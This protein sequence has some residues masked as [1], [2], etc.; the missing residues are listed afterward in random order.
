MSLFETTFV[1]F[2]LLL[3]NAFFSTAEFS[4][5]SSRK[6]KLQQLVS[7]GNQNA[8]KVID[9]SSNPSS[10]ITVIQLSLNIIA[11]L[12]GILGEQSFSSYISG[13]LTEWGVSKNIAEILSTVATVL[14]I[15]SV[16][17]VFAE[18]IPKR[19]AFSNPERVA[20][21]VIT[22]LLF[23]LLLF[24]PLVF[25][26][27]SVAEV[28]LKFFKISTQRDDAVTFEDMSAMINQGAKSGILEEKSII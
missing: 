8:Q 2:L 13:V 4:I 23:F 16:F 22:P 15:T 27:S 5:A 3:L 7:E 26:L 12:S 17:I 20:T 28:I 6:L 25:V 14:M 11:I 24:K 1:L 18:L 19:M 9:L 21:L 10:F